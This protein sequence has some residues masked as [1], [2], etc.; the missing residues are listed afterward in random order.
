MQ[1]REFSTALAAN[2]LGLSLG[3]TVGG[4]ALAQGGPVEGQHYVRLSQPAPV[5]APSGKIEV[6]EFFSYG[7]PH[8]NALEPT[9]EDWLKKLPADVAFRRVPVGFNAAYESYQ[10][11]FFA[12]EAM[13]KLELMHKRIFAAI[14]Q[15]RQF[16]D[17]ESDQI[18]FLTANGVDGTV[19][20]KTTKEFHVA[21]KT[22]Q[23][24]RLSEAYKIDG[25]PAIGVHGR[26]YTA[27]SLAGDNR[28]ALAVADFLIQ[29]VRKGA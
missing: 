19:F 2:G 27:G 6:V 26:Y 4:T 22:Q 16:L 7:C 8:C 28:R 12:L 21:T 24:K 10:R 1:R 13:G 9:L 23:A 20:A 18:A 14:H 25:V 11:L 17:K 3:L 15:Q 29:R 5:S